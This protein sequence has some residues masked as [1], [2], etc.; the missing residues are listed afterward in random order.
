MTVQQLVGPGKGIT[1]DTWGR[2]LITPPDGGKPVAYARATTIAGTLD[3]LNGLMGWKQRMTAIGITD[4]ADLQ[5]A[6]AA[7]RDD[8]KKVDSIVKEAMDAAAA[9]AAATT[10]TALHAF[11][12]HIDT[13]DGAMPDNV[14]AAFI[15][16]LEAYRHVAA[17]LRPVHIEEMAVVDDLKIA[18]TPDRIVEYRD[19][20]Y[21]ADVKTGSIDF[22]GKIA[23]QLAIYANAVK[24]DVETGQRTPWADGRPVNKDRALII[25]LPAGKGFCNLHWVDIAA[26]WEA[27]ALAVQ[28]REWRRRARTLTSLIHN[29]TKTQADLLMEAITEAETVEA[30]NDLWE[31]HSRLW[32]DAHTA[33]AAARKTSLTASA[34]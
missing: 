13:H 24:Y 10:G 26:G 9:G 16:D 19:G 5:I 6:V 11:T 21:V 1:R 4:R 8:K 20:L 2:P 33:A 34:A 23:L 30:L 15:P 17:A 7:H 27:V 28:V 18:G 3:D 25:H 29:P 32:V 14:P 22:P 12:E 31:K